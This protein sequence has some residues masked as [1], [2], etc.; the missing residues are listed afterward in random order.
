MR[1]GSMRKQDRIVLWPAYFDSAKTRE[2]GRQIPKSLAVPSPTILEIKNAVEKLGLECEL[3]PNAGYPKTPWLKIGT[4]LV[5]K[6]E[7]KNQTIRRIA[8]QLLK[9]RGTTRTE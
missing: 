3:I 2:D 8:E 7:S 9:I 1:E 4:L 6:N 5:K